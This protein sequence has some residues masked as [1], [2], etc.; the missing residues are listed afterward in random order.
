MKKILVVRYRFIGDT[1]L[2]IPFLRNLRRANPDAQIDMIVAPGSGEILKNCPYINHLIYFDTTRKHK[3]ERC[4]D[5]KKSFWHYV[6]LLRQEK[7]DKAYVLKRSLSSALLCFFSGIKERIGYNTELR[8]LLLT[9]G[10]D[11][12]QDKHESLCYLDVLKADGIEVE[13]TYLE[14]WVTEEE[15]EKVRNLFEANGIPKDSLKAVVNI[16]ATNEKKIWDI[17]NFARI[18]EFLIN[19]KGIRVVFT[20]SSDDREV[21]EKI[22]Y[23][24]ELKIKP[25]NLCGAIDLN[26][27]LA[28]IKD[29]DFVL[30]NDTGVLHMAASVHTKCIGL[31]GPMPVSKWRP[32]GDNIILKSNLSC[33]PCKLKGKCPIYTNCM[34]DISIYSV[35]YAI[36]SVLKSLK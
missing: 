17:N 31:F 24:E 12:D 22:P 36:D 33:I 15:T 2:T 35:K 25:L 14:N 6:R 9:K 10:L 20:G 1:L 26:D 11:Y 29:V 5:G 34:R 19:E 4:N 18:I 30:G 23:R 8:G 21:Y 13:D 7:Y 3:Y 27:S 28:I 32:L 16:T